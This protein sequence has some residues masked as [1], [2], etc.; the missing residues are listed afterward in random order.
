[1]KG[2]NSVSRTEKSGLGALRTELRD[3]V[4]SELPPEFLGAFTDDPHDLALTQ[5][6][7]KSLA[8]KNWLTPAWPTEYGGR[9][10][11]VWEQTVFREEMWA[12]HEPRGAQYM[13]V[14]WVGPALIRFGTPRQRER[15]LPPIA[16]GDVIWCQ[17][18]SEPNAG[19]DLAA[20]TTKAV[21]DGSQWR[22]SGQKIW[23]SYATMA[24]WCFLLARTDQDAPRHR[25]ISV[26]LLDMRQA[27]IEVRPIPTMI[28]PH[29]LNEVFF[30]GAIADDDGLLGELNGGWSIVRE[31]L[32]YERIGIARY[33]RSDR[34]LHLAPGIL[35]AQ[36]DKAPSGLKSRWMRALVH[37]RA[38]R[39]LAYRVI[40][41]QAEGRIDPTDAAA[42]RIAVT[43]LDQEV[44]ELLMELL[45][46]ESIG[47][48][49]S[50]DLYVRAIEDHWR[51]AQASTVA[52]GSVEMQQILIA[53]DLLGNS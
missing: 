47:A 9:E 21:R 18:F 53:R 29:H 3:L 43:Q 34:L 17:G 38:A 37:T 22:I 49:Q 46:P 50:S 20:L 11:S 13:G 26:F 33:A 16:T 48:S 2:A 30:D 7:C 19:S 40:A 6:F 15:H 41:L 51:Y 28:G 23:T 32:A 52:S 24:D 27:E 5:A 39:L 31:A 25:G 45:G 42:Y 36:W 4:R 1:M 44:A 14:N 10:A 12:H 35:S 8:A